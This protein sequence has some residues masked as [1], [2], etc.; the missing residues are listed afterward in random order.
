MTD[1]LK[2]I[3]LGVVQGLTEFLPISSS[4]HLI[5]VPWLFGWEPFGLAFDVAT[6]L[7]TLMAVLIYFRNDLLAMLFGVLRSWRRLLRGQMPDDQMGKLGLYIALG[8]IPAIVI[9]LIAESAIDEYFH[10]DPVSR[11]ALALSAI[12]MIAMGLLLG[13]ADR[14]GQRNS[15]RGTGDRELHRLGLRD[16]LVVGLAQSF[17]LLPGVSRS[18]ST[19]TAGLFA[20]MSRTVAARFSFLLGVPIVLGAGLRE[21]LDVARDGIPADERGIFAAGI[22]S[23]FLVGY[24]AIAGLIQYLSRHSTDIFVIY[25]VVVGLGMLMLLAVGFRG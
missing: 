15:R 14:F 22:L 4:A 24:V 17:A 1:I 13:A 10:Q 7:G 11:T 23:A 19:I 3:V 18:G 8:T 9:G 25:R 12:T 21:I 6:H 5:Y 20:G 2:A 16:A